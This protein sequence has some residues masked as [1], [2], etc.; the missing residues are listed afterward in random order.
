MKI[1][2]S[3]VSLLAASVTLL[4]DQCEG[5]TAPSSRYALI[6]N[7]NTQ[8]VKQA[9]TLYMSAEAASNEDSS[10]FNFISNIFS[11]PK[12]ASTKEPEVKR[13]PDKLIDSDYNLA[14]A[15]LAIGALIVLLFQFSVFGALAGGIHAILGSFFFIQARRIRFVFDET[16]FEL[17]NVDFNTKDDEV[18]QKLRDSGENFVVGG[19]NR[20]AYDTFVNW[21]FFPSENVPVLVYFKETQTKK[22]TLAEWDGDEDAGQVHFFPAIANVKQLKEQFALRGCAKK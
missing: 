20:W 3:A 16:C 6:K 12:A 11:N 1:F 15:F 5:F 2:T 10:P 7:Q 21:E 19:K 18:L 4:S 22:D 8:G 17:K 13:I 9:S 14:Y